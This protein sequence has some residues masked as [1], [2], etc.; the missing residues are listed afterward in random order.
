MR[1]M[2][3]VISPS[4]TAGEAGENPK[5]YGG[6][7]YNLFYNFCRQKYTDIWPQMQR[8]CLGHMSGKA[9]KYGVLLIFK[10]I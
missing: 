7:V 9:R 2:K 1:P 10:E 6:R 3:P 8:Y 4:C 5:L